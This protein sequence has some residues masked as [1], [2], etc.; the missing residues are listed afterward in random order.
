MDLVGA[1]PVCRSRQHPSNHRQYRSSH[2]T[3][4]RVLRVQYPSGQARQGGS[5]MGNP[6][7]L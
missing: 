5:L 2:S 3:Y 6:V 1:A 4:Y 7:P